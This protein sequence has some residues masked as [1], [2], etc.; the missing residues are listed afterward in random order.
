M[1]LSSLALPC[2]GP[3]FSL[4]PSLA[5]ASAPAAASLG[6]RAYSMAPAENE[7]VR[8][9]TI[10]CVRKD[11]DVVMIGDGQV[12]RGNTVFKNNVVKVREI[13]PGIL[14]GMAGSAGDCLTL[15]DRLGGFLDE[16]SNN[17]TRACVALA[18]AWRTERYMR[19]LEAQLCVCDSSVSLMVSGNG[20]VIEP[21]DG[22]MSAGSGS[23]Y[24]LSAAKALLDIDGMDAEQ[25]GRKSMGIAADICVF[26]NRNFIV[27]RL[28]N[29]TDAE[30]AAAEAPTEDDG[31]I[32]TP[33]KKTEAKKSES[34]GDAVEKQEDAEVVEAEKDESEVKADEPEVKKS[35]KKSAPK[36]EE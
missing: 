1:N 26:T 11:K 23:L 7:R 9:T 6:R 34:D 12:S 27:K 24:A 5:R 28:D 25:I 10:L 14:V 32:Y 20:D 29:S 19:N 22:V 4:T 16:S 8:S 36:E 21:E 33:G 18:K 31:T 30:K 35:K 17:L 2:L 15:I 13:R 3:S